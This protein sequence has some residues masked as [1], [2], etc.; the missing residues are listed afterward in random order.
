MRTIPMPAERWIAP[1]QMLTGL[2]LR[3]RVFLRLT[4][5]AQK[6]SIQTWRLHRL[7]AG[8]FMMRARYR[9]AR[10]VAVQEICGMSA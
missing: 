8:L 3:R 1:L 6:R 2:L 4:V 5:Q 7:L 10:R 9:Y